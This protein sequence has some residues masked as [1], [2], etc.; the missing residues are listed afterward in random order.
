MAKVKLRYQKVSDAKR[1]YEILNN[2]NFLYF[3]VRPES[4]ESERE[5]LKKNPEKRRDN[6][7]Y[8]YSIL[9]DNKLVGACGIKIDQHRKYIGEIGYFLDEKY[10][11]RGIT[12]RAV[13][14]LEKI[15][16]K[17][18][19]LA[20]IEV[21]M[22]PRNIASER[23]AIKCGYQKEG[24]MKKVIKRKNTFHDCYLYAKVK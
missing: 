13:R 3:E 1:F 22:D 9:Y 6:V 20:R 16:F 10:W 18:L 24:T 7:E 11:G 4:I 15:G 14:L 8:N 17:T 12:T 2:P 21:L 23:V 5:W 19:K